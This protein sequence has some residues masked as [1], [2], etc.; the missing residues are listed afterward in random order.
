MQNSSDSNFDAPN[1]HFSKP[2]NTGKI[3]KSRGEK[4]KQVARNGAQ[5]LRRIKRTSKL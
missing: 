3:V 4:P 5:I 2:Q 1:A